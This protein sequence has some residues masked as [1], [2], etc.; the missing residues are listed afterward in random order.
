M[1]K[2]AVVDHHLNNFHAD[3]YADLLR[4][5][6][7]GEDAAIVAAYESDPSGDDWCRKRGVTRAES[8]EA[9][10][11]AA[12]AVL[13]LAPDNIDAHPRLAAA[14]LPAGKPVFLDK[15]LAERIG[16]ARDIVALAKRHGTPIYSCSA[17]RHARELEKAL[18]EIGREPVADV[19]AGGPGAWDRYGVHTVA[20]ALRLLGGSGGVKRV[21]DTGTAAAR[22]V[23][24]DAGGDR[25]AF[26]SVNAAANEWDVFPWAFNAR[27]RGGDRYV[28]GKVSDFD[29]FYHDQL[30]AVLAFFR[31]GQ[32]PAAVEEALT[33]VAVIEGAERSRVADGAWQ[34]VAP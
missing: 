12:D 5:P 21:S 20:L 15:L 27:V 4:G 34:T 6:L 11:R 28:A 9:A 24:L 33:T 30:K 8:P 29:G 10:V 18:A 25:R 32:P 22:R 26:L 31:T 13:L 16:D 19:S 23:T 7:A 3:K 17:L 1:L 14:V 2:I